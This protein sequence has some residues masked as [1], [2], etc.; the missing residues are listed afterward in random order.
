MG[1]VLENMAANEVFVPTHIAT[2]PTREEAIG[3]I[4]IEL[5]CKALATGQMLMS[6]GGYI[7]KGI[8]LKYG[9]RAK[10]IQNEDGTFNMVRPG[11]CTMVLT[12][13]S[14]RPLAFTNGSPRPR[15]QPQP[16]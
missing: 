2:D 5:T 3:P 14:P 10:A 6:L 1:S 15:P 16:Q 12:N 7:V 11:H 9:K 4:L 8:A 13:G